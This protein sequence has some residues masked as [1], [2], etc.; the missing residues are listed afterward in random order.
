[1]RSSADGPVRS[2]EKTGQQRMEACSRERVAMCRVLCL[3]AID[4][5]PLAR[6][7]S[8]RLHGL[9]WDCSLHK[10]KKKPHTQPSLASLPQ[11]INPQFAPRI[12]NYAQQPS[13]TPPTTYR[14]QQQKWE[15]SSTSRKSRRRSRATSSASFSVYAAGNFVP[16]ML[17][18]VLLVLLAPTR[19]AA[20]GTRLSKVT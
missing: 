20:S 4:A 11:I 16:S 13:E 1:M 6:G 10:Q 15:L 8:C 18:T 2:R 14:Q 12:A 3:A 17:S 7:A 19:L 5:T 9:A